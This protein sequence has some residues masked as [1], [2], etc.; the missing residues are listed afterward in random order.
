MKKF[1]NRK[2]EFNIGDG[3]LVLAEASPAYED[4]RRVI[5]RKAFAGYWK[6]GQIVGLS[7]IQT[8]EYKKGRAGGWDYGYHDDY[9]PA[10]LAVD[11]VY[12]VYLVRF[13]LSNKPVKVLFQDLQAAEADWNKDLPVRESTWTTQ[14]RIRQSSMMKEE[15][16]S[17]PFPR[18]EEGRFM[19]VERIV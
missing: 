1:C 9:E 10:Y 19:K 5:H 11:T 6:R 16:R 13:G 18:D 4:T 12:P 3:V 14:E 8:G 15:Y 7:V 2:V 17:N